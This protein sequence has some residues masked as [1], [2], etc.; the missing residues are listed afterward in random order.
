[1]KASFWHNLLKLQG[2]LLLL[3]ACVPFPTKPDVQQ[4]MTPTA[5]P[6]VDPSAS[7]ITVNGTPWGHSTCFI[8]A[9]EGSSRFQIS[10]LKDLGINSYHIY[11]GMPRWEAQNDSSSYGTPT[12]D[13]I[14]ANPNIINWAAWDTA[15]TNPPDGS[16][17]WWTHDQPRWHGNAR[18]IF[19]D[20]QAAGI[21]PILT[22]RNRDDKHNPSWSPN[23]P[24][25]QADWNE[26]W[27]HVFATVYWLNVRN[28]Y[29][30]DDFEMHNEPNLL[31]QGWA[32]TQDQYVTLLQYTHDAIDFVYKTYLPGR[33][34]HIYAP[35][36]NTGSDWP[37][38]MLQKAPDLFDR[39][40]IHN[41]SQDMSTYVRQAHRWLNALGRPNDPVW[42]S[43]W[44]SYH[45]DNKYETPSM[46]I[47]LINNLIRGS[48]PGEDYVYGSN[49]FSLYDYGHTPFGLISTNGTKRIDYYAMRMAI[50]ALQGCRPT[51]RSTV[52]NPN[53][54]AIAT[55]DAQ[56]TTYFLVT[57]QGEKE[58][59][60]MHVNLSALL[61]GEKGTIWQFDAQHKDEIIGNTIANQGQVTL[62]VPAMGALLVQFKQ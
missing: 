24:K 4:A 13:Q 57:N 41:Y 61:S 56:G 28:N 3:T 40:D 21:H 6:I 47:T 29:H 54:F 23:P 10:D 26:W 38:V 32:G 52:N 14:K 30:V 37:Y 34:Y 55:K 58:S 45:T 18:T 48:Q 51:Y 1:M 17:Y 19:E 25:T 12:I 9:V 50:R 31:S 53:L 60:R 7:T 35:A 22:L 15:M 16:D 20:L 62:T 8:G 36:T 27:E 39:L 2:I 5:P 42:I 59:I 33:T 11:G 49:I 43:E 46:G 44:G